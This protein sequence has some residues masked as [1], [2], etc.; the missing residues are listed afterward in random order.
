LRFQRV[1]RE[2]ALL[3]RREE[4]GRQGLLGQPGDLPP[5]VADL[6][7]DVAGQLE[8][9]PPS[10]REHGLGPA[11]RERRREEADRWAA[12]AA[13]LLARV[14]GRLA[15]YSGGTHGLEKDL[16][17]RVA[18]WLADVEDLYE[19]ALLARRGVAGGLGR[20]HGARLDWLLRLPPG[21][22]GR[23]GAR[24]RRGEARPQAATCND[25][26]DLPRAGPRRAGPGRAAAGGRSTRGA[27]VK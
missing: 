23:G 27:R 3:F 19:L 14:R 10:P 20:R 4:Q 26:D 12:A 5:E 17:E 24:P 1:G 25:T 2:I 11:E 22:R 18:G 9:R 15:Q 7:R 6:L 8:R 21:G 13:G 16:G